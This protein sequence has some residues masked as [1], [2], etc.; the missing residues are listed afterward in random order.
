MEKNFFFSFIVSSHY[1]VEMWNQ[2]GIGQH[3]IYTRERE[4][5]KREREKR[6]RREE[7]EE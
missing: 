1:A 7:S 6:E 2:I 5:E 3:N 4:R